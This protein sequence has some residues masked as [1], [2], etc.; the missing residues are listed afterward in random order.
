VS[1]AIATHP[2][3]P[4]GYKPNMDVPISLQNQTKPT[5]TGITA[6]H[7]KPSKTEPEMKM[8][9]PTQPYAMHN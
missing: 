2:A 7:E 8:V 6:F 3:I 4:D 1:T 5:K 9:K